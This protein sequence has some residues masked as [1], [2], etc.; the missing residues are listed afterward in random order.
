M[1]SGR[2]IRIAMCMTDLCVH[3]Y[4]FMMMRQSELKV[5]YAY[6]RRVNFLR[7]IDGQQGEGEPGTFRPLLKTWQ[8]QTGPAAVSLNG[9]RG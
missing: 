7:Q 4:A 2:Q 6:K 8:A 9:K 1:R 3:V 5:P